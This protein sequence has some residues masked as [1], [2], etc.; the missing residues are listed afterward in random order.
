MWSSWSLGRYIEYL[1]HFIVSRAH[2]WQLISMLA[3]VGTF[4]VY[5]V[6][7]DIMPRQC[8]SQ[9]FNRSDR[10]FINTIKEHTY[11]LRLVLMQL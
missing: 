7:H 3:K 2:L 11:S 6:I 8:F 10:T 9:D 1:M 4:T 5:W